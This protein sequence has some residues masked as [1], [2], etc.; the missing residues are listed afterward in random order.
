VLPSP[1]GPADAIV[2]FSAH[3]VLSADIDPALVRR[4]LPG[5][6]PGGPM[7]AP[8]V[9][10]VAERIGA[11]A[12]SLDVLL[13]ADQARSGTEL[14]A[15][16][17]DHPRVARAQTYRDDVSTWTDTDRTGL[18]ILGRGLAGRLEIS[19]EVE[20]QHRGTGR[21]RLLAAAARA[22]VPAGEHLFAQV[23]PGNVA[24]L[25]AFLA[26]GYRPI[27]AEVL[28]LRRVARDATRQ[29]G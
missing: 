24:S 10:W 1:G 23:A 28:F 3:S 15:V 9:T 27:G 21:G 20:P 14:V 17:A 6:D 7:S 29:P 8:F 22:L 13:V 18:A 2:A 11:E 25:R 12:G 5:D 26:A 16:E 4:A 19:V